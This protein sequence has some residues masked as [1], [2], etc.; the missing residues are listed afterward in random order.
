M[1]ED[2]LEG[3]IGELSVSPVVSSFIVVKRKVGYEEGYI[4]IKCSL[5]NGDLLE[6][7]EYVEVRKAEVYTGTYSFHWQTSGKRLIKRWD[8]VRHHKE[9]GAFPYHLHL[10]DKQ[11]VDSKPMDL[12]KV[13]AEIEK[14]LGISE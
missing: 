11:A 9:L 6:F 10:P 7:A 4:R 13:L 2:Y 3:I 12:K 14:A 1:I 5:A 8:N